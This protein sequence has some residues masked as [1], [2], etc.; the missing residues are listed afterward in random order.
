[1]C[2]RVS[3]NYYKTAPEGPTLLRGRTAFSDDV[4]AENDPH[5]Q[6]PRT[7]TTKLPLRNMPSR[8]SCCEI[9]HTELHQDDAA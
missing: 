3:K 5:G 2:E 8:L 9:S 1:M 6:K 4:N 7:V